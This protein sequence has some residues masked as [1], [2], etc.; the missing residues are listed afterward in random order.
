MPLFMQNLKALLALKTFDESL[1]N[2][3]DLI[4]F[5]SAC[6]SRGAAVFNHVGK[7]GHLI[8]N[9]EDDGRK[10]EEKAPR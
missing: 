6:D 4:A 9:G 3:V 10:L 8:E 7:P 1:S 5:H 2:P